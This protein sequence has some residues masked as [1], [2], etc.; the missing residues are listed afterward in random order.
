M[1]RYLLSMI[2][3]LA[4]CLGG[5]AKALEVF[6]PVNWAENL[7]SAQEA[8]KQTTNMIEQLKTQILQYERMLTDALSLPDFVTG[9]LKKYITDLQG[10]QNSVL[11]RINSLISSGGGGGVS[12][13]KD[14][15]G[16]IQ[17]TNEMSSNLS[18]FSDRDS[19]G[20]VMKGEL[21]GEELM[22]S[23]ADAT[24]EV[25]QTQTESMPDFQQRFQDVLSAS[26]N[27]V[28]HQQALQA[29]TEMLSLAVEMLSKIHHLLLANSAMDAAERETA[30][31]RA[32]RERMMSAIVL[33][34]SPVFSAQITESAEE[35]RFF[36]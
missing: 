3:S 31:S 22:K 19:L 8:I 32:A 11:S 33:G 4:L 15:T 26:Q 30:V 35:H 10:F 20:A 12:N 14:L 29:Q 7:V 6:D 13:I 28:G 1:K 17:S 25:T 36:E 23:Y 21:L 24:L 9:D 2:L 27:A 16:Q 18:M 34:K 5:T